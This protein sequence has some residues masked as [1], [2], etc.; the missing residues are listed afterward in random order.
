MEIVF[1][2]AILLLR[3]VQ[4]V[5]NKSCSN[6]MPTDFVGLSSYISF[7]MLLS[8][9]AAVLLLIFSG[10]LAS[11]FGEMPL[12]GWLISAATGVTLAISSICSLVVLKKVSV[13]LG[14]LFGAAGLLVPTISGVF[15]Y[16]QSVSLGQWFGIVC[17][18]VAALFLAS[19]STK[20]NGKIDL[21]AILLLFGS[22]LANGFTMLLQTLYKNYVPNGN[23]SLYSFLQ[24]AI[25]SMVLFVIGGFGAIKGKTQMFKYDKKLV[26]NTAF[27]AISVFGISQISTIA[28]ATIPVAI[29]FPISDGG[30][31]VISAIVA[32]TLFG[33]RFTVRS[34]C[35]VTIGVVGMIL[36][37]LLAA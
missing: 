17:L 26:I 9:L 2:V 28:S 6:L 11:A 19:S 12:L 7:Q 10:G 23:V 37:K 36:V 24:F 8:A 25:P 20:T 32:A 22:M 4:K 15:I 18:F 5:T 3:V 16:D 29:L 31:T 13:V 27:A 34:V 1:L 14:A 35:G 21:K 30:G 33:E